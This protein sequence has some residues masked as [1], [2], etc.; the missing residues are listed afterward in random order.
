M[1]SVFI[2]EFNYDGAATSKFIEIAGPAGTNLRN[3][4]IALYDEDGTVYQTESLGNRT[5]DD[6]GRGFG[7]VRFRTSA[8]RADY[9]GIA[10][11]NASDEVV[12]F[13]SYNGPNGG[14][15]RIEAVDGPVPQG[16][17][18]T[19]IG[20]EAENAPGSWQRQGTGDESGDFN[21][22]FVEGNN[23]PN[24]INE[25]QT[26][27]TA[28]VAVDDTDSAVIGQ[29]T[30]INLLTNDTDPEGDDIDIRAIF[31]NANQ[32]GDDA[33]PNDT[34]PSITTVNGG[35]VDNIDFENGT[36]TYTNSTGF[37]GND[38]FF[39]RSDDE[40]GDVSNQATVTI[41][42]G[43][44]AGDD[45]LNGTNDPDDINGRGGDD[46]I[47]GGAGDDTLNGAAGDD[48]IDG[49]LGNDIV[50]GGAGND[51]L[52]GNQGND[53]LNGGAGN[54]ILNGNQGNDSLIG[55]TGND[56]LSGGV[57]NDTLRGGDGVD[58]ATYSGLTF[59][60][61]DGNAAGLDVNLAT[62]TAQHSS[63]SNVLGSTDELTDIEN[64]TGT[65]RNDRFIG[66]AQNNLFNG[67][68]ENRPLTTTFTGADGTDYQVR[69]D[70]VEYSGIQSDFNIVGTE[71]NFTVTG[72]GIGTDSLR[73]I[74]FLKFDD[75]VVAVGDA[76]NDGPVAQNDNVA[77]S[78]D[79]ALF[80]NVFS[81]NGN[82]PDFD[83]NGDRLRVTRV[84]GQNSVGNEIFTG[85]G[86]R[87]TLRRDGTFDYNPNG[88]F[89]SLNQGQT[90]S[91][92]FNY[93]LSDGTTTSTATVNVSINGVGGVV[94]PPPT[95]TGPLVTV[96]G[97]AVNNPVISYGGS[98][99]ATS[100]QFSVSPSN[101]L[102]MSGNNFKR[103]NIN[104]TTLNSNSILRFEY[105]GNGGETQGIGFD[106][107]NSLGSDD[108]GNFFQV[109][110]SQTIGSQ[111]IGQ[112]A[113]GSSNGFTQYEIPVGQFTTGTFNFLTFANDDDAN[114]NAQAQYRNVELLNTG[115]GV[116]NPP[117]T[118]GNDLLNVSIRGASLGKEVTSYAGA[119]QN[120]N[121]TA[122]VAGNNNQ[123]LQLQGN[124]FRKVN[125]GGYQVTNNTRLSFGFRSQDGGEV[126]GIGFDN[127]NS[128]SR[129]ADADN[130]FQVAGSDRFGTTDVSQYEVGTLNGFTQ[131]VIPVAEAG[132]SGS[133]NFLTFANDDDRDASAQS[134]FNNVQLS[135]AN[136]PNPPTPSNALGITVDGSPQ[137]KDIL[138]YGGASQSDSS[139]RATV[140]DNNRELQ[141]EG[142]GWRRLDITGY[143]V[144]ANTTLSFEFRSNGA[145]EVIGLGFDNNNSISRAED[146][147]NF[148]QVA[149]TQS[150]G[151][152]E[153]DF[154]SSVSIGSSSDGFT[155]YSINVGD[156]ITPSQQ[157]NFLTIGNDDD[158]NTGAISEFRNITLA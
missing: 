37:A 83:T 113:T 18:S 10:L 45:I 98:Q 107:N 149:G 88:R 139:F 14:T 64:V 117:P 78:E 135:E 125:I 24:D 61:I 34:N 143:Q 118:G 122:T 144:D 71:E 5:I 111:D 85:S 146:G 47:R 90:G 105:Q 41:N 65:S 43:G 39:Y 87:L 150:F 123:E 59:N 58:T 6:E 120:P 147:G 30:T 80:G 52:N 99:D 130:F 69:G 3:W 48:S 40:N 148:F 32:N 72:S 53:T 140:E 132:L 13:L 8:L 55:G 15:G 67:G 106:N 155:S 42:V 102:N 46:I 138:S 112:F 63:G 66:N 33:I 96:N 89:D 75:G 158:A 134:Q 36:A 76:L 141:L 142:N 2:N 12:E 68:D 116:V 4:S 91:D 31:R 9:N 121:I 153:E 57:G 97:A 157:F 81:D 95:G 16:Q 28:P 133:F 1:A 128:L 22:A 51:T 79:T 38:T 110:G 25:D 109:A 60:G 27:N 21:F 19:N 127:N 35:V 126:Q 151:I 56:T 54:D 124:G 119:A 84:N 114:A 20:N 115:T 17:R 70:V 26:F 100:T 82:G 44:G 129:A 49:G 103:V 29:G 93:T 145:G 136:S 94:T 77:T 152:E 104:S 108:R 62:G 73:D 86:A 7:A 11:V 50:R 23:S 131:Y 137:S 156:F 101:Q 154:G 74:E 92:S